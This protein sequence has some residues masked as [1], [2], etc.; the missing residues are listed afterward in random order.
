MGYVADGVAPGIKEA[1]LEFVDSR[2]LWI[3]K[4]IHPLVMNMTVWIGNMV[5][6]WWRYE[7]GAMLNLGVGF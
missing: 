7:D 1:S 6:A 3:R 5:L 2:Q 4:G